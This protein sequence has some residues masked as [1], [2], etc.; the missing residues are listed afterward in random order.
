MS[1]GILSTVYLR[2]ESGVNEDQVRQRYLAFYRDEPF[3][4]VLPSGE[5][6]HTLSVRGTNR[7]HLGLTVKG[8]LLVVHAAIDNLGKGAAGQALQCF[9]LING[10]EETLGLNHIGVYP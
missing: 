9:N 6:P 10:F 2:L 4:T 3:V 7:C 5:H 8:G 1:R